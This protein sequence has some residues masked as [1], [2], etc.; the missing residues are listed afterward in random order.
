M[1]L[2]SEQVNFLSGILI[3]YCL[4]KEG[5]RMDCRGACLYRHVDLV[6]LRRTSRSR[7]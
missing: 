4:E 5:N 1:E 2:Q 7:C 3:N 6:S